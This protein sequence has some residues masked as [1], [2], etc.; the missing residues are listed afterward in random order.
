MVNPELEDMPDIDA[1]RDK[2]ELLSWD[3]EPGDVLMFHPLIV[4]GS[5]GNT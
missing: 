5:P 4:H 3:L 2:Y 1:N